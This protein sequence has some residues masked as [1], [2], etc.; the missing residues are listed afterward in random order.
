MNTIKR[1]RRMARPLPTSDGEGIS[2]D[3]NILA[4]PI[5]KMPAEKRVT[6]LGAVLDLLKAEGGVPLA[7]IVEATGWLPHT[8]RAALTGLRKKGHATSGR[9]LMARPATPSRP[10]GQRPND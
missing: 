4:G 3:V 9:L 10:L 7:A 5:P 6:K 8:A 1:P 2:V